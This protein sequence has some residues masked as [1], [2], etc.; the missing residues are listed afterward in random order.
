MENNKPLTPGEA[1]RAAYRETVRTFTAPPVKPSPMTA[2]IR[3]QI[4][5]MRGK[6]K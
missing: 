1:L 4:E 3:Q 6:T 2:W 5:A